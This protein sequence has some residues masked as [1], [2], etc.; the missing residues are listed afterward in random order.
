MISYNDGLKYVEALPIT[1]AG[2]LAATLAA[3]VD[4]IDNGD[5]TVTL[6]ADAAH[7]FLAG[8]V[9]FIEGTVNYNGIQKIQAVP[10]TDEITIRAK[11]VA[12][13]QAGTETVKVAI[14]P[15]RPYK[16]MGIRGHLGV[17]PTTSEVI[18]LTVD[19]H[20]GAAFDALIKSQDLQGLTDWHYVFPDE[21]NLPFDKDD[22]I[23]V[24]WDN[25]DGR[26]YG[27]EILYRPLK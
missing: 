2:A 24:A 15:G 26:T 12:E 9:V 4:V 13:E 19:S 10:E 21:E 3:E 5:G 16:L 7:G 8:S 22:I 11:Y 23:R 17:A 14:V 25:T 6:T 1:G 27:F 18:A 20:R